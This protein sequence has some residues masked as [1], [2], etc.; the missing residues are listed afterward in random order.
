MKKKLAL[1]IISLDECFGT[2]GFSGGGHKVT[3]NLILELIASNLFDI[4]IYCK[5]AST[6]AISELAEGINSVTVIENKKT[7]VK[8]LED[9]LKDKSYDYVLSSDVL[10][11]FGNVLLH[12][13]SSKFKSKNG[14]NPL[15]Q[16][17]LKVYNAK[18]INAQEKCFAKNKK[19]VFTVSQSLK[20][21]Y[22]QNFNLDEEKVFVSYPAVDDSYDFVPQ[23]LNAEFT[24]GGMAG[25][26]LNKGGYLLLMALKQL[27]KSS[28][29]KARIIFPKIKK[30]FFFKMTVS[31]LGLKNRIEILPKQENMSEYYKSID[32]YVLPSLNEAFGLVVTEAASNFKP[33][34]VSST[35]GV[36]ELI[37]DGENGFVFDRRKNSVKNLAQKL[38]E[39]SDIYFNDNSRFVEISKKANEISKKLDW[40]KFAETIINNMIKEN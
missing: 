9:K 19:A 15:L 10:L 17:V 11:P 5:K 40:K 33:S 29:L 36:R 31:L 22:V 35:T 4:D 2:K 7:F 3:K 21:D 18:K 30:S 6:S 34:L 13:N 23:P 39:I 24:I 27:P 8:E 28:K 14:K 26:G 20:T 25:G 12:S 32:C 16:Q 37:E 38:V 1:I